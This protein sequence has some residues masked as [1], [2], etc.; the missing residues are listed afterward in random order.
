M[1][2]VVHLHKRHDST[3]GMVG[4]LILD[5]ENRIFNGIL[6]VLVLHVEHSTLVIIP[7]TAPSRI[8]RDEFRGISLCHIGIGN[9]CTGN[10]QTA[11]EAE[12]RFGTNILRIT[13]SAVQHLAF[14]SALPPNIEQFN[15]V[16]T[17]ILDI[18][19]EKVVSIE[20]NGIAIAFHFVDTDKHVRV[21]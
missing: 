8:N 15:A 14:S 21:S 13:E 16:I 6:E 9:D 1:K 20:L 18:S 19:I 4:R 11:S 7:I 17:I 10:L 5:V 2:D 3:C 12:S